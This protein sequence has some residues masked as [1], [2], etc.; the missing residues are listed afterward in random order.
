MRPDSRHHG[1]TA[2]YRGAVLTLSL[3]LLVPTQVRGADPKSGPPSATALVESGGTIQVQDGP[4]TRIFISTDLNCA[5][6]P[7]LRQ[8]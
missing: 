6:Q 1:Q 5:V 7:H 2:A 8:Q 4:L 3:L